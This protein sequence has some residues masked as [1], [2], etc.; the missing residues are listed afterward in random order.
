MVRLLLAYGLAA[1][2]ALSDDGTW[3]H[4]RENPL[5]YIG[6]AEHI[7]NRLSHFRSYSVITSQ[8]GLLRRVQAYHYHFC[9]PSGG[10]KHPPPGSS[11]FSP[12]ALAHRTFRKRHSVL[13]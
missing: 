9:Q 6:A 10:H 8:D 13:F 7:P 1:H 4:H 3:H 5:Q 11:P 12:F 2:G